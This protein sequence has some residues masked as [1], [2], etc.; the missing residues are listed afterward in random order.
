MIWNILLLIIGFSALVYGAEKLVDSASSLAARLNIPN[1]VIGLTIVAFGTSSPEL[2]VNISAAVRGNSQIVLGNIIGSNIFNIA[3]ILGLSAIIY[4]LSTIKTTRW[5]DAPLTLLSAIVVWIFCNDILINNGNSNQILRSEGLI[6]LLF[7]VI[8]M[9][10]NIGIS[11]TQNNN[12]KE[13]GNHQNYTILKSILFILLGLGLL[14]IGGE[15]IVV[16]SV[17]IAQNIGLSERIIALTI[18]SI[19]TSLPELATSIVAAKKHNADIAVGNIVG[20]N[21]FNVFFILG[22]SGVI[23]NIEISAINQFDITTNIAESLLLLIF[24]FTRKNHQIKRREG[25]IML[26]SYIIYLALIIAKG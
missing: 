6:M 5:I 14:A 22:L 21:I 10:Y 17:K 15:L 16:N 4:P 23:D 7:F 3:V 11:I 13:N 26:A 20:S 2:V 24:M 9:A 12:K 18:V 8:F 25:I 1:M 19:G